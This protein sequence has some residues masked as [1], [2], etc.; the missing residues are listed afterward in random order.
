MGTGLFAMTSLLH[1]DPPS[2]TFAAFNDWLTSDASGVRIA[3]DGRLRLSPNLRRVAQLPE[4]VVWAAVS[5][6]AAGAYLSAGNE[7]KLFHY[8]GG[9]M[10]PLT[11]VKGGIVFAMARFGEDLIVAPSGEGKLLRVTPA[12]DIKPFA[13]IDARLVWAMAV[14]GPDLLVA[15]GGERGAVLIMARENFSRKLTDLPEE[16]A[17]TCLAS[18][19]E[20]GF[21]LG[22]HGRGLLVRY[23]GVRNGDRLETLMATGFEEIRA[24][25]VHE[26]QVFVGAT[27]GVANH[28]A[29]GTLERREGYLAE[30][31]ITTKSAVIRL[32]RDRVPQTLWQSAQSQIF[33]M[34][35]WNGQLL[36]GTGNRSRL[37]AIPLQDAA[38]TAEPFTALQD[39]GTAQASGF[40]PAGSDLLVVG[41]NP[42]ELH[43]I[44][45]AQATEGTIE[46]RILK[47]NPLADW[48]RA[49]LEAETPAGTHVSFQLRVGSTETPD[50]TWTPWTPP[51]LSGERSGLPPARFAQFRLKL[52]ST[53]GS[54]TPTVESVRIH[55][56]NRNLA[57][58]W[59][60]VEIMPPGLVITRNAPPDDLG[61]ERVPLETQKLI[62]AMAYAGAEKH[63]FRRGAQAFTFKVTDPNSDQLQYRLRLIP[64]TGGPMELEKAWKEKFFTFDT[65]AVPDGKYRLEVTASDAPSQPF[66][67]ALTSVWRTPPFMVDHTPPVIS[68]LTASPEGEN[69]K[70]MFT[71]KDETSMIKEAAF[72]ADG[73]QWLGMAPENRVFDTKEQ[74]FEVVI[75]RERIKGTRVLV[76]VVDTHNNEQTATVLI[77]ATKKR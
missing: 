40:L 22:T 17:F 31:G 76:K 45:Q 15:G 9:Q 12:G 36:V 23:T 52:T 41:S 48:G 49:Y 43:L 63:S 59:E 24:L 8:T 21:Y 4:G 32:D 50:S 34:T 73:D 42:A 53:H 58:V 6:G 72:S 64:E 14:N 30:T 54:A 2:A 77:A 56:A 35:A 13:D 38:R 47:G 74:H 44:N 33:A 20:G 27:N 57:P 5:D 66:N 55:W 18:D 75:P 37:F 29:T 16:T 70:L 51:L 62:P 71:A 11:Q 60:N 69:I 7:G 19:G 26:G 68:G 67:A 61:I 25:V 1:A 3:A 28:F 65:L 46:S 39:L 10:K